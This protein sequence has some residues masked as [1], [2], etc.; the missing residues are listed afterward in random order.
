[1]LLE[2]TQGAS[3]VSKIVQIYYS[4]MYMYDVFV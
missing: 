2:K 1:M 4:A 3:V